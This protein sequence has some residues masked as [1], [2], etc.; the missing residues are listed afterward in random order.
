M[1]LFYGPNTCALGIHLLLEETGASYELHRLDFAKREQHSDAYRAINP[2][3]KV[4][5]LQL[6]DGAVLTEFQAI[7]TF[8]SDS[9]PDRRLV[10]VEPFQRAQMYEAL[11]Y[12]VGFIHADGF[13][14][15]FR[16]EAFTANAADH[17][18]VKKRG[19]EVV[20]QGFS[21]ID[22]GLAEKEWLAG[23]FSIAD[24]ALFYVSY[25]ALT[26]AKIE[27]P[28]D[29]A[30]HFARMMERPSVGKALADEGLSRA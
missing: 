4:P 28:A 29:I 24:A 13:R 16:P 14:R 23:E 3:A 18:G 5:A 10:P 19:A 17:D 1:K 30:R 21:L 15:L 8:L 6:P 9:H 26:R 20:A 11:D 7:A 12:I 27:T 25:W 2:K 22:R